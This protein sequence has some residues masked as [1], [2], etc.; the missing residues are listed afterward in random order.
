[1]RIDVSG[2]RQELVAQLFSRESPLFENGSFSREVQL[3]H[4]AF[5][6]RFMKKSTRGTLEQ[7]TRG[8]ARKTP[9]ATTNVQ[10]TSAGVW[11]AISGPRPRAMILP[12]QQALRTIAGERAPC[13]TCA[14]PE[15]RQEHNRSECHPTSAVS[16]ERKSDEQSHLACRRYRH[17]RGSAELLRLLIRKASQAALEADNDVGRTTGSAARGGRVEAS[18]PL[19]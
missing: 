5:D 13:R 16:N 8:A 11:S 7:G 15:A 3:R 17:R 10:P 14:P 1:M 19:G 18:R 2:N 9:C 6:R 12:S 4:H